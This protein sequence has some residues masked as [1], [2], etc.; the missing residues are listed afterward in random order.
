[1]DQGKRRHPKEPS[2]DENG[3]TVSGHGKDSSA[4]S[5]KRA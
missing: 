3:I 1:L 4:V 5:K 2:G